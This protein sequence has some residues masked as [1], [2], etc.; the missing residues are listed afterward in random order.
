M[1]PFTGDEIAYSVA[2]PRDY[3]LAGHFFYNAD[4]GPYSAFPQNYEAITTISMFLFDGPILS[5]ILNFFMGLGLVVAAVVISEFIGLSK[6]NSFLSAMFI[7]SSSVFILNLPIAKNDIANS[8]FQAWTIVLILLYSQNKSIAYSFLIGCVLGTS[9]GIKYNSLIFSV[10]PV[11]LFLYLTCSSNLSANDKLKRLFIFGFVTCLAS[12]P[13]YLN[14]WFQFSNPFYPVANEFFS[15]KNTFT[16]NYSA[17]FNEMF[18]FDIPD[19]SW[20]SGNIIGFFTKLYK[21][22][23]IAVTFLGLIGLFFDLFK[24]KNQKQ[25]LVALVSFALLSFSLRFGF[26]EPRYLLVLMLLLAVHSSSLIERLLNNFNI[27]GNGYIKVIIFILIF[28]SLNNC[29][30]HFGPLQVKYL[31]RSSQ[32]FASKSLPGWNVANYLNV[33]TPV[34]SKIAVGSSNQMFYYLHRPYYHIHPLTE[35]DNLIGIKDGKDF[36]RLLEHEHVEYL[37]ISD[38]RFRPE[39][40][41]TPLMND[42]SKTLNRSIAEL[43]FTHRLEKIVTLD[44]VVIYK[45]KKP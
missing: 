45:I 4:Y 9:I 11:V 39:N 20:R 36:Y 40:S 2:L 14:N 28:F 30:K 23:G 10:V 27:N 17:M 13:W 22:F 3:A 43:I 19:F 12:F 7:I 31:T 37:A 29:L 44:D 35:K 32:L 41:K 42:F 25:F 1:P 15:V 18:Y 21:E 26:W 34:G 24:S 38:S 8:F 33:N 6:K 5:K 16:G